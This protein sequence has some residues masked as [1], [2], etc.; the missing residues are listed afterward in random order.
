MTQQRIV[1]SSVFHLLDREFCLHVYMYIKGGK[2]ETREKRRE[3]GREG[4]KKRGRRE[5]G[6]ESE[7]RKG[8]GSKEGGREGGGQNG[9][10][11]GIIQK[12]TDS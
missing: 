12:Y 2:G 6:G 5:E 11:K 9:E 1:S 8:G 7:N 4:E 10:R 3:G